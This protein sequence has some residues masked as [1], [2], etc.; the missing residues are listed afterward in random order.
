MRELAMWGK[1]LLATAAPVAA[2]VLGWMLGG[3]ATRWK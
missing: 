1:A 3:L 2:F